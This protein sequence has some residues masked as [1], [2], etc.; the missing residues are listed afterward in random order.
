MVSKARPGSASASWRA[1]HYYSNGVEI[2]DSTSHGFFT[3]VDSVTHGENLPGWRELLRNGSDATTSLSGTKTELRITPG[4]FR[5]S[6]PEWGPGISRLIDE[7][8]TQGVSILV[9]TGSPSDEDLTR[10]DALALGKFARKVVDAQTAVK[11]G[12]VLGELAQTLRMIK[13]PAQGLR[14]LVDDWGEAARAIRS[15]RRL[16]ALKKHIASTAANLADAWLEYSFGWK[17]LLSDIDDGCK[18]LAQYNTGQSIVTKRIHAMETVDGTPVEDRNLTG[19]SFAVWQRWVLTRGRS[20]VIYRGAVRVTA[21]DPKQMDP[22]LFGFSPEQ[23]LPTAWELIPYSF[24]IDYFSNVGDIVNGWSTLFAKLSWSNRTTRRQIVRESGTRAQQAWLSDPIKLLV[25]VPCKVV[26]THTSVS[27]AKYN[28]T[29]V[30]DLVFEMP[31]FGSMR[32][33]NIAALIAS[34]GNDRSW[35]YD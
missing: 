9:P 7:I 21:R 19:E 17:P 5:F 25:S 4:F 15:A 23:F 2:T 18:A 27:R 33:L 22:A 3:W 16:S 20:T 35:S 28:G 31:S 6:Y 8:G 14:R 13:N 26:A 11:G 12:V 30:P 10:A 29:Y 24:L 32:W 1:H 34:R